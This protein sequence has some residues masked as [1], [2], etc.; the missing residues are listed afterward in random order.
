MTEKQYTNYKSMKRKQ[1][2]FKKLSAVVATAAFQ[3]KENICRFQK[4]N[5]SEKRF[6]SCSQCKVHCKIKQKSHEG[7]ETERESRLCLLRTDVKTESV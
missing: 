2:L 7:G 3:Q 6:R 5:P 1:G 4:Q